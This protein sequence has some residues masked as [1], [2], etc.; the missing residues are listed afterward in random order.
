LRDLF[1]YFLFRLLL[2][3]F[4]RSRSLFLHLFFLGLGL[5]GFLRFL[6]GLD[7]YH[8]LVRLDLGHFLWLRL[9]FFHLGLLFGL[10]FLGFG[11]RDLG[12]L[13]FFRFGLGFRL[14]FGLDRLGFTRWS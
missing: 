14:R 10:L 1:L 11:R 6:F 9:L 5:R 2:G 7:R 13:F 8:L 4:R 12:D 3:L